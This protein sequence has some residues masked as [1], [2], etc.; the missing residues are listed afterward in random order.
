[1][2]RLTFLTCLS[3]QCTNPCDPTLPLK[4]TETPLRC[5]DHMHCAAPAAR[6][7][8]HLQRLPVQLKNY[9]ANGGKV[10]L[11][12]S[13]SDESMDCITHMLHVWNIYLHLV[14]FWGKC[15][16]IYHTWSLWVTENPRHRNPVISRDGHGM[17]RLTAGHPLWTSPP[18]ALVLC[19]FAAST[20]TRKSD[21]RDS[22]PMNDKIVIHVIH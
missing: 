7:L 3:R 12:S 10:I 17:S 22:N 2:S 18:R 14:H 21:S 1:M 20:S 16:Y 19:E 15:R 5:I 4:I 13:K 8:Q 6:L 9:R 11:K